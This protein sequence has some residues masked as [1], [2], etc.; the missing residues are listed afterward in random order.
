MKRLSGIFNIIGNK[1][2]LS[3][4]V[5]LVWISFFD[6][7]DLFTQFDRKQ[8]LKKLETSKDFY[9]HEIKD[10]RKNLTDLNNDPA[11]LE[12]MARENFFMKRNGEEVFLI[13]DSNDNK[14]TS[15]TIIQ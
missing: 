5:F 6:R 11:I 14:K 15:T 12:K 2:L 1:Y 13:I 9:E 4:T 10:T 8:E 3:V 7:N